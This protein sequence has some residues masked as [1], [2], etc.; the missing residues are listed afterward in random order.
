MNAKMNGK[1]KYYWP[2]GNI[3]EGDFV[4]DIKEGSG[5]LYIPNGKIYRIPWKNDKMHG[6]GTVEFKG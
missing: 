6:S 3:Y 4:N 2:D 5:T 1:G